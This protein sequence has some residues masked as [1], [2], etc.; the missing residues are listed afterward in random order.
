MSRREFEYSDAKS[1]KFWNI[2]LVG[3]DVVT[4][5]GR[6]GSAGQSTSKSFATAEKAQAHY[7][8]LIDQK[9]SKGYMESGS[10]PAPAK[11]VAVKKTTTKKTPAKKA[12]KKAAT[13]KAASKKA[14]KSANAATTSSG[15]R[16]F[17]F[18]SGSSGKFWAIE[19]KGT[20]FDVTYGKVGTDGRTQTKEFASAEKAQAAYDKLVEEKTGK[21]Y[22][23]VTGGSGG[24]SDAGKLPQ[25]CF[26]STKNTG[27]IGDLAMFV[28]KRVA[29]FETEKSIKKGDK[30]VYRIRVDWEDEGEEDP[31]ITRLNC[32]L[33]SPAAE[34]ATGFVVGN[35]DPEPND[36]GDVVSTLIA[37]KQ[38][39]P[40]LQGLFFG[41]IGQE[42]NEMSWIEMKDMAPVVHAFPNLELFRSRGSQG[43]AYKNLKHKKLRALAIEAGGL[44]RDVVSQICKAKLPELE[45]LEIW[46]GTP[47]YGGDCRINDLQP[48]LKGKLFPKL[49]H[50]ALRNSEIADEIAGVIVNA[51]IVNQLETLDLSLGTLTDE[52]ANALMNL[53]TDANLKMLDVH[54]HFMSKK[55]AKELKS[56]LPF[57]VNVSDQQEPD[58]WGDGEV[59]F[60]AVG[61]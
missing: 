34:T 1:H 43:L 26:S 28:G 48:I 27:D 46:L 15:R 61:E 54:Y 18:I 49:K 11:K 14:T 36:C 52:G 3:N 53:P 24:D 59:R 47:N 39:L 44:G 45:Y 56:S 12:T 37:N 40:N 25:I 21:G 42:E 35:W 7:D 22:V 51:P 31:F 20:S 13:K 6:I 55:K 30:H 38:K 2:D 10:A 50:L 33:D 41:E 60:V 23:E 57:T 5:Y 16:E 9:T 32:F 4:E 58:D 19:S 8:K 29:D 17:H